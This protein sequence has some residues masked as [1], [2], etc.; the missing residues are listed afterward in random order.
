MAVAL[1]A[2]IGIADSFSTRPSKDVAAQRFN[3]MGKLMPDRVLRI[4]DQL[5][6]PAPRVHSAVANVAG[7]VTVFVTHDAKWS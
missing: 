7:V 2:P 1:A 6:A 4:A 3:F 5:G